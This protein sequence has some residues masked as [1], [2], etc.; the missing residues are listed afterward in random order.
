LPS[1]PLLWTERAAP[2]PRLDLTYL[3]GEE[4]KCELRAITVEAESVGPARS[5]YNA[6]IAFHPELSG[7]EDDGY[8]VSVE[9]GTSESRILEVLSAIEDYVTEANSGPASVEL[10]GR[11]YTMHAVLPKPA[12]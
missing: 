3:I 2:S 12:E 1:Q 6:L 11:R 9:L 5:L 4:G 8:S 10:G 7:S